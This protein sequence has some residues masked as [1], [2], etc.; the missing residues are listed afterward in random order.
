MLSG[1]V[2]HQSSQSRWDFRARHALLVEDRAWQSA[3]SLVGLPSSPG[4][5]LP[6]LAGSSGDSKRQAPGAKAAN[7]EGCNLVVS[8]IARCQGQK[9]ETGKLAFL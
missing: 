6:K 8:S 5:V 4:S 9:G 1:S 3:R 2:A 7:L